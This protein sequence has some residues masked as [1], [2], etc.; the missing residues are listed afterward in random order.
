MNIPPKILN[1]CNFFSFHRFDVRVFLGS[2]QLPRINQVSVLTCLE[3]S[4][5]E[6]YILVHNTSFRSHQFEIIFHCTVLVYFFYTTG[7]KTNKKRQVI[8]TRS[9]KKITKLFFH[10]FYTIKSFF[11]MFIP[12]VILFAHNTFLRM[13]NEKKSL[14]QL[15]RNNI[16]YSMIWTTL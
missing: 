14:P 8:P 1:V 4:I 15:I 11:F 3:L 10:S 12:V 2:V 16:S 9:K 5:I 7:S 13:Y 6:S